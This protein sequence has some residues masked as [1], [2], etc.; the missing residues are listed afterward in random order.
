VVS[1]D[2]RN[3]YVTNDE[4]PGAVVTFKRNPRTSKLKFVNA[5]FNGQGSVT[6]IDNAEG[7]AASGDGHDVYVTGEGSSALAT[8]KR[9]RHNGKLSFVNAKVDG[10]GGVEGLQ[11]A[12]E[13]VVSGDGKNVYVTASANVTSAITTFKRNRHTGKLKFVNAKFDGQGGVPLLNAYDVVASRD[14][15]KV[16]VAFYNGGTNS[17]L[18]T[19]KRNRHN[20]KLRFVNTKRDDMGGLTG[21]AGLWR[22]AISSDDKSLYTADYSDSSVGIFKRH[23]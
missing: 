3:V 21:I 5:K 7:V 15:R 14:G 10:V 20:G 19:F 22:V 17:G 1:P 9:N 12:Y 2:N 16:Y 18:D 11:E 8:F 6:G 13:P 4:S 23:R